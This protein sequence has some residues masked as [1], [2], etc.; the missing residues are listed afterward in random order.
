MSD[1][2]TMRPISLRNRV[3]TITRTTRTATPS[4]AAGGSTSAQSELGY[5]RTAHAA[6]S[7]AM[8]V[9]IAAT[10][11]LA[12]AAIEHVGLAIIMDEWEL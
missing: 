10:G 5:S 8:A 11:A 1:H 9:S 6:F 4:P 2:S 3:L 12:G 7:Q